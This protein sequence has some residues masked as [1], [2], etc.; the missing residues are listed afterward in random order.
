MEHSDWE[1]GL[2]EL[3]EARRPRRKKVTLSDLIEA[4][5]EPENRGKP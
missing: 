3:A 4:S 5:R 1:H 2:T